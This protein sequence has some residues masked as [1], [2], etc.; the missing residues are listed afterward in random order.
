MS[1]VY[2]VWPA[3][4]EYPS[5]LSDQLRFDAGMEKML[6]PILAALALA[7]PAAAAAEPG[8]LDESFGHGGRVT[9]PASFAGRWSDTKVQL[10]VSPDGAEYLAADDQLAR[11]LGDGS[12]DTAFGS[13]GTIRI[14]P[15]G[16]LRFKTTDLGVDPQGR[17]V[18]FGTASRGGRR[19]AA[20]LRYLPD[21]SLDES[22]GQ[23]GAVLTHFGLGPVPATVAFGTADD[24]GRIVVV[25]GVLRRSSV[26]GERP[27][28]HRED[29]VVVRLTVDGTFDPTFGGLRG[30]DVEP[31][32]Q[33]AAMAPTADGGFV[34]AGTPRHSCGV[35]PRTGLIRLRADGSRIAGFGARGTRRI[36]GAAASVAVDGEGRIVVL[37]RARQQRARDEHTTKIAR[38]LSDGTL[39]PEFEGGWI[40]YTTEGPIYKWSSVVIRSNGHPILVGTLIR[41]PSEKY[42]HF[43]RWFLAVPLRHS[44]RLEDDVS[45]RGWA[46]ITR[47]DKR[48]DAAASEAVIDP[49]GRLLIGGTVRQP[50]TAPAGALALARFELS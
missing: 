47:F 12:L 22:F 20:I 14:A 32:A 49:L 37:F 50:G 48:S 23:G 11:Y 28:P 36:A 39:D 35:G 19:V 13:G 3:S 9:T 26:C 42:P 18:A 40:V 45:W 7:L 29:R 8:E 10:A 24:A 46:W 2:H 38:L 4:Q 17:P 27:R 21:G 1:S 43:H 31:L 44:G 41:P 5:K 25:G 33:V 15:P 30:T 34:L 16:G 6:L